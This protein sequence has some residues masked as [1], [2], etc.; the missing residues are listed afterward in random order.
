MG[1][2]NPLAAFF[3]E[4]FI[5]PHIFTEMANHLPMCHIALVYPKTQARLARLMLEQADT[6][7]WR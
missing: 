3:N 2:E 7:D 4:H 6:T 5:A 1:P